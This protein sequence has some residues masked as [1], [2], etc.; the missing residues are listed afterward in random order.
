MSG[1][2]PPLRRPLVIV[3]LN[4][5]GKVNVRQYLCA[6]LITLQYLASRK[7]IYIEMLNLK[8]NICD[9]TLC[10]KRNVRPSFTTCLIS[11]MSLTQCGSLLYSSISLNYYLDIWDCSCYS[12]SCHPNDKIFTLYMK[13][14]MHIIQYFPNIKALFFCK[15]INTSAHISLLSLYYSLICNMHPENIW[16]RHGIF[17]FEK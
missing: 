3:P 1:K 5:C 15:M 10:V 9:E 17:V 4:P 12:V 11:N 8:Q 13:G 16:D 2:K 7:Q 6:L 14:Y